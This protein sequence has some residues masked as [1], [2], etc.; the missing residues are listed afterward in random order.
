MFQWRFQ[1]YLQSTHRLVVTSYRLVWL[2]VKQNRRQLR[3]VFQQLPAGVLYGRE[4]E[5]EQYQE[6]DILRPQPGDLAE[7]SRYEDSSAL[8]E[9]TTIISSPRRCQGND[10]V[11][12]TSV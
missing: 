3:L 1:L 7:R 6:T 11:T 9:W 5:G 12:S 4:L 10:R 2:L 8:L